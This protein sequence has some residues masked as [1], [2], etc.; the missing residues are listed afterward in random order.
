MATAAGASLGSTPVEKLVVDHQSAG[1]RLDLFVSQRLSAKLRES[2]LSRSAIQRL[3]NQGRLTVNGQKAKPSARVKARDV[4]E[5]HWLPAA[6]AALV[7][8]PVSLD[9][10]YDDA[11]CIVINKAPGMVVHPAAGHEQGTVVNALLHAYPELE[12]IGGERRPGIVH[13]LDKDTSGIMIIAK[14]SYSYQQLA[15]QFEHRTVAKEYLA[16]VWGK[17]PETEGVIKRPIGRHRSNRKRMSSVRALSKA[18]QAITH[19]EVARCFGL[20]AAAGSWRWVSLLRVKPQTGR[21]HQIRVHLADLGH[22]LV[23]DKLYGH[24]RRSQS[25]GT[26]NRSAPDSFPRQALHAKKLAIDHPRTGKRMI[27]CAPVPDDMVKL[28]EDLS[29]SESRC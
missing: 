17:M 6:A 5:I 8:E 19:W 4:I 7:A 26:K 11:E 20:Y 12:G 14:N 22:P 27:F 21:T 25:P 18:R 9:V 15:A 23:G 28:L 3:V 16:L 10:L 29:Q 13:R 2:G 24:K 1:M